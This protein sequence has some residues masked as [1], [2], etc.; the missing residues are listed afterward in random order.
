MDLKKKICAFGLAGAVAVSALSLGF[1]S[2]HTN[3]TANGNVNAQGNWAVE[4]TDA[5][6]KLSSGASA[7]TQA[8][9]M[10]LQR[11]GVKGD[12]LLA[13]T[14][15][16]SKWLSAE[17]ADLQG[18]Q[19]DEA[20]S[21]YTNYYLVDTTKHSM[22]DIANLSKDDVA[23]I[24]ADESTITISDHLNAYYRYVTGVTDG[25]SEQATAS[26]AK[27]VDG[28]LKD[29]AALLKEQRPDTYQ[30][31]MLVYL[32]SSGGRFSY[33]IAT[34]NT[35]TESTPA[36]G[37]ALAA[38]SED[39]ASVSYADVNL[40]VPGA[41][42]EYTMTVTNNGSTDANLAGAQISLNT[43]SDQLKLDKPDLADETLAPGESCT[44]SFV[45]SVPEDVTGDLDASAGTL[46]V[47]LPYSQTAVE[48]APEV[49]VANN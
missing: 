14:I 38:I 37:D 10:S 26:A 16:S 32:S 24:V 9:N 18:T 11:T 27:V 44:V 3:I 1:A 41:W 20:L 12:S 46:T 45:L 29:S 5:S 23:A 49:G 15:S 34:V 39:K 21:A 31:Y 17:Q 35:T 33:S 47:T 48:A 25:S 36:E 6:M 2:W 43:E 40:G 19:S 13:S 8:T 7:T 4:I 30:D 28:L 42:A 22:D